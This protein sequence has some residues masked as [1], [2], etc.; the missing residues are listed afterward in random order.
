MSLKDMA[1][2]LTDFTG[3]TGALFAANCKK[4][5]NGKKKEKVFIL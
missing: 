1:R 3:E 2:K 5:T 4:K